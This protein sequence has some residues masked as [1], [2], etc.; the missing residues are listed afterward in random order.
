MSGESALKL[1]FELDLEHCQN[2]GGE[3]KLIAANLEGGPG[4]KQA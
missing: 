2:C 3:I 4:H 1:R